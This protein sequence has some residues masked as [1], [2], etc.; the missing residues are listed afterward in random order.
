MLTKNSDKE[1]VLNIMDIMNGMNVM[2]G[3]ELRVKIGESGETETCKTEA[4]EVI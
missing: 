2:N 1:R 3:Q 4:M